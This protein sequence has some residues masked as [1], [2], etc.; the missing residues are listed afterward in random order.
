MLSAPE[1]D[2]FRKLMKQLR[3]EQ[4]RS[5]RAL[6]ESTN[7]DPSHLAGVE[8]GRR[9]PKLDLAEQVD[10][11]LGAG[12]RLIAALRRR[13]AQLS[14]VVS[15]FVGRTAE[16]RRIRA[17]LDDERADGSPRVVVVEGP[18][19]VG[20]SSLAL[21]V[22][23]DVK[24]RYPDGQLFADLHGFS[25]AQ[26]PAHPADVLEEFLTALGMRDVPAGLSERATLFRSV[27]DG[28]R[29]LLVLDN[30]ARL[31]QL[32]PLLPGSA[33]CAVLVTSRRELTGLAV[34]TGVTRVTVHPMTA[35]ESAELVA[36]VTGSRPDDVLVRRCGGLPLALRIAGEWL[37][38]HP[39]RDLAARLADEQRRLDSLDT[40]DEST[41]LRAVIGWSY[42]ELPGPAARL[43]RLLGRYRGAHIGVPAATALAGTD[44]AELLEDLAAGHLVEHADGRYRLHDL[45]R[46]YAAEQPE[47]DE[48][49]A[50]RRLA[51]WYVHTARAAGR[52]LAPA[53]AVPF[54][55]PK[56]A[57]ITPL[58]FTGYEEALAWCDAEAENFAPVIRLAHRHGLWAP[59]W[60]LAVVLWDWLQVRRPLSVWVETHE[61]ALRAARRALDAEADAWVSTNLAMAFREQRCFAASRARLEYALKVRRRRGD[62]YGQAWT[63]A[64]LVFLA[65]DE[66]DPAVAPAEEALR[67]FAEVGD[68]EG[69]A[70]VLLARAG[71]ED[72]VRTALRL[73]ED[74]E[75]HDGRG[76]AWLRLSALRGGDRD[77]VERAVRAFR[78]GGDRRGEADAL[79]R[80]A[81]LREAAGLPGNRE[82]EA[83]W[84]LYDLLSDPRADEI[85]QR[86]R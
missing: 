80:L 49:D 14:A 72:E 58:R 86:M 15:P 75:I 50:V 67:I 13:P 36:S 5:F 17:A 2:T 31:D 71:T 46:A 35:E 10:R 4:G 3:E 18:P 63:L 16:I 47:P 21:R 45:L 22:A 76:R 39:G 19:G 66:G 48:V 41:A 68:Q 32:A 56:A 60:Q 55:P 6:A 24:D 33:T 25:P 44:A 81:D 77:A 29:V 53:R 84:E 12:G 82:R 38:R 28:R 23:H 74:L 59:A 85:I 27:L 37:A 61:A 65:V 1:H 43:F 54:T 62:R 52:V 7:Y 51:E 9:A 69:T 40:G 78:R 8:R 73:F 64:G 79:L 26:A 57:G 11:A 70:E 42:R 30:A 20:K 34:R 83:A